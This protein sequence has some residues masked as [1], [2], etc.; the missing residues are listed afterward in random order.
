MSDLLYCEKCDAYKTRD[1]FNKNKEDGYYPNCKLCFRKQTAEYWADK[2]FKECL[3]CGVM[4]PIRKYEKQDGI[5]YATCQKCYE[6]RVSESHQQRKRMAAAKNATTNA[7]PIS[8]SVSQNT[9][10]QGM[11]RKVPTYTKMENSLGKQA[12]PTFKKLN[13]NCEF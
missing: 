9:P 1:E 3:A 12:P 13:F 7:P 4:L 8:N 10:L 2:K 11:R 6:A 5:P